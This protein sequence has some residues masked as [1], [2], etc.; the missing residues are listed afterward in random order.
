MATAIGLVTGSN[1]KHLWG[2]S[3]TDIY[4]IYGDEK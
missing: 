2:D 4:V 3:C 1:Y